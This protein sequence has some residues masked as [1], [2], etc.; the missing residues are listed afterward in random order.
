M[1]MAKNTKEWN[2]PERPPTTVSEMG[3]LFGFTHLV[4]GFNPTPLKNDG[5]Q[6]SWDY[7]NP[8]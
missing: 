4:A 8:N 7:K 2:D 6:V 5:L 3:Q 1:A